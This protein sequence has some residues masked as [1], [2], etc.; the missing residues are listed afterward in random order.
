[1]SNRLSRS[2][3]Q[4]AVQMTSLAELLERNRNF[5]DQFDQGDLGLMPRFKG[6]LITCMDHRVDPAQFL[7]LNLGDAPVIRNPGG[8]VTSEV[9]KQ[10]GMICFLVRK[11]ADESAQ[12]LDVVIIHHT[13]CGMEKLVNPE[14]A[15]AVSEAIGVRDLELQS[16]AIANP[17]ESLK[18]DAKRLRESP[19]IPSDSIRVSGFI[20]RTSEG[21]L[22]EIVKA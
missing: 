10:V 21:L 16:I 2:I 20:Y 11:M 1:M 14:L 17:V 7:G 15:S 22:E 19:F 3:V 8:R 9:E 18:E 6:I 5:A 12:K 4:L 13:D